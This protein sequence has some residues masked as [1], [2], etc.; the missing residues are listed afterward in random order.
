VKEVAT[1]VIFRNMLGVCIGLYS[2]W[3]YYSFEP[4]FN[5]AWI[6]IIIAAFLITLVVL[7]VSKNSVLGLLLVVLVYIVYGPGLA[8]SLNQFLPLVGGLVAA[9]ALWKII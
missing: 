4:V 7:I 6:G 2:W 9:N 5:P 1:P 8:L 3:Y